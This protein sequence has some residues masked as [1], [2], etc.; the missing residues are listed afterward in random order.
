MNQVMENILTRR[1]IRAFN[2]K[3]IKK[4]ELEQILQAAIYAPSGMNKQTWQFTAIVNR[5]KIQY[6][7]KIVERVLGR[8][9]YDFYQPAVLVLASNERESRWAKED[10]ACALENMF[11]AAHSFGIG[12]V[13]INQLQDIG[14]HPEMRAYLREIG[15][16]DEH[17]V[18]GVAA[19]G[20]AQREAGEVSKKGIIKI[21]E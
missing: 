17:L 2:E 18:Y 15:I 1:S 6:L 10:N 8:V 3:S 20:Y 16:P 7:A 9:G 12:S 11:L 19:L 5:D 14:D 4:E 13:W 21:V